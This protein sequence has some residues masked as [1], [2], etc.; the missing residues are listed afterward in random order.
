MP[1]SESRR[2]TGLPQMHVEGFALSWRDGLKKTASFDEERKAELKDD[3]GDGT[4][5]LLPAPNND[6]VYCRVPDHPLFSSC[7]GTM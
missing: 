2:A 6:G 3:G 7:L 5:K 4:R 1:A